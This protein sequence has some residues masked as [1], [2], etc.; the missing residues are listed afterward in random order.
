MKHSLTVQM[1]HCSCHTQSQ[2]E[3]CQVVRA[4]SQPVIQQTI[5]KRLTQR[6]LQQQQQQHCCRYYHSLASVFLQ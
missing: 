1:V 6:T 4:T 3:H 2:G 5:I